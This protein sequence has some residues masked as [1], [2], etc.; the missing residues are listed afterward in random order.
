MSS[1]QF[2]E[3]AWDRLDEIETDWSLVFEPADVVLRYSR[4]VQCYLT[5]LLSNRH[6]AE[7]VSQEFFLW[8]SQN[9]LPRVSRSRGRFRDYLKKVV[10]NKALN[11]LR[12]K[13]P[14]R[15]DIELLNLPAAAENGCDNPDQEWL[16]N[17]RRCLLER[18][19]RRLEDYQ[20]RFPKGRYFTVL[21]LCADH[22]REDSRQL[23]GRVISS[24][25]IPLSA[26]AFRKQVSRARRVFAQML[27]DEVAKALDRPS[28]GDVQE[29]LV[30]LG[31]M[32]YVRD[33][34]PIRQRRSRP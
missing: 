32:S 5:A 10:R 27:V 8:V 2:D 1:H 11:F 9:G 31:L 22:P 33:Y 18:A 28:A 26:E 19:W 24:E 21:R 15:S 25:G 34:L 29:E 16:A 30:E 20:H 6:D 12:D 13:Q 14:C 7:E 17:W 23:A 4:A 3:R